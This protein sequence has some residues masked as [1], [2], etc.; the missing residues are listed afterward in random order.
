L[1]DE[2]WLEF[3]ESCIVANN[4]RIKAL[5]DATSKAP[6]DALARHFRS[7]GY[8]SGE[9]VPVELAKEAKA[10]RERR[11]NFERTILETFDGG[12]ANT[13]GYGEAGLARAWEFAPLKMRN[14]GL[15]ATA[16]ASKNMCVLRARPLRFA[17]PATS[18]PHANFTRPPP[19]LSAHLKHRKTLKDKIADTIAG[20]HKTYRDVKASLSET[21]G[22]PPGAAAA[23]GEEQGA[24]DEQ[25]RKYVWIEKSDFTGKG[26][27]LRDAGEL[28]SQGRSVQAVRLNRLAWQLFSTRAA[29]DSKPG[30]DTERAADSSDSSLSD[31][32]SEEGDNEEE[33]EEEEE[34]G[35]GS[36]SVGGGGGGST[37]GGGGGRGRAAKKKGGSK[38][39]RETSGSPLGPS[40]SALSTTASTSKRPSIQ[41]QQLE[42][43]RQQLQMTNKLCGQMQ[44]QAE[45]NTKI[46]KQ[47]ADTLQAQAASLAASQDRFAKTFE[48]MATAMEMQQG[49]QQG[50]AAAEGGRRKG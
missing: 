39:S 14:A 32:E 35:G 42:V 29:V 24:P 49:P 34:G 37:V 40:V 11:Q 22:G 31:E 15:F 36:G 2:E 21:G 4:I 46:M 3:L 26:K 23:G 5:F 10:E 28:D 19:P 20:L 45:E 13:H 17:C 41:L 33:E 47:Q 12:K 6:R 38:R 43:A 16:V 48:R 50:P 27:K 18:A 8:G 9:P 7:L 30:M 44:K 25:T 1:T